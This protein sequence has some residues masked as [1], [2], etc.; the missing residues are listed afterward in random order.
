[1]AKTRIFLTVQSVICVLA[2]IMLITAAAGIYR[3]GMAKKA[4]DPTA[5][6][7][8]R[9]ES[10]KAAMPGVTVIVIG[11]L[12]TVSCAVLGIRDENADKPVNDDEITRDLICM[13]VSEP[14]EAM[15]KERK[16]QKK[17]KTG[18]LVTFFICMIPVFVYMVNPAH[19]AQSDR[20]G[21]E[22]VMGALVLH[23]LPWTVIGL[24]CLITSGLFLQK[25]MKREC[26]AAKKHIEEEKKEGKTVSA[27]D[28][29]SLYK[30]QIPDGKQKIIRIAV[31]VLAVIFIIA[32][33]A[34]GSMEAVMIKAI[35]ICTECVGLG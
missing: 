31:F 27:G 18:A 15:K 24:G 23:I 12:V 7:Y 34:N 26:E 33:I 1:M 25:S 13:R 2:V 9:E 32:G 6:V 22:Q 30:G 4:E 16:L 19:F 35:N 20:D 11:L 29:Q 28:S 3:D 17:L 21:L 14:D 8:T 10:A 5:Y